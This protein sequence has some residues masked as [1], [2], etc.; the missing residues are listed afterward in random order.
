MHVIV[1]VARVLGIGMGVLC[2]FAVA[3]K[4]VW[5]IGLAYAM[6]REDLRDV[7]KSWSAFPLI[8]FIPLL[9]AATISLFLP[10]GGWLSLRCLC[11]WGLGGVVASY[12]HLVAVVFLY[13]ACRRSRRRGQ[14]SNER[15]VR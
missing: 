6:I 3:A 9:V 15:D 10:A 8:E 5:N 11:I 2:L 1:T 13:G 7:R 14:G 12:I 4:I